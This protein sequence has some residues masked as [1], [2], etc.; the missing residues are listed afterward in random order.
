[1]RPYRMTIPPHMRWV[2]IDYPFSFPWGLLMHALPRA[3]GRRMLTASGAAVLGTAARARNEHF[4]LTTQ[5]C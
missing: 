2:E 3:V 1:M 5:E 4:T